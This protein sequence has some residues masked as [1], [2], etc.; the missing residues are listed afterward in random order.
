[1]LEK[2]KEYTAYEFMLDQLKNLHKEANLEETT[3]NEKILL[4]LAMAKIYEAISPD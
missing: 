2:G 4:S 1:M 3:T